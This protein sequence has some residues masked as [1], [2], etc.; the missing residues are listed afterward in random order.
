MALTPSKELSVKG[1]EIVS[2]GTDNESF[3]A[4]VSTVPASVSETNGTE[5]AAFLGYFASGN[6]DPAKKVTVSPALGG[7]PENLLS[8]VGALLLFVLLLFES[9]ADKGAKIPFFARAAG[10]ETEGAT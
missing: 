6:A 4:V 10:G 9:A 7:L 3:T 1:G 8:L 2:N 5:D